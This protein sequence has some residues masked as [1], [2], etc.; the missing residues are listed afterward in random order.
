[1]DHLVNPLAGEDE[2]VLVRVSRAIADLR[3][4]YPHHALR[5]IVSTVPPDY[6]HTEERPAPPVIVE[7]EA[8]FK[9]R[10]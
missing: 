2:Q 5:V 1:M 9:G 7:A 6:P 10:H 3:R 4:H 8:A